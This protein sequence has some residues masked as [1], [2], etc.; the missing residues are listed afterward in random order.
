[1]AIGKKSLTRV[2]KYMT[3]QQKRILVYPAWKDNN[4]YKQLYKS[5]PNVEYTTYNGAFF[6]LL[7][8]FHIHKPDIIHLH[9]LTAYFAIDKSWSFKF[10]LRYFFSLADIVVLKATTN[11]KVV[12]TVH[13][14]YEHETKHEKME[15]LAKQLVALLSDKII[16]LGASAKALIEKTYKA[17]KKKIIV[18][19]HGH[20][21]DVFPKIALSKEECRKELDI[22]TDKTIFLFPGTAKE[23]KGIS[24][25]IDAFT[26]WANKKSVLIIAG[27]VSDEKIVMK[28]KKNKNILLHN[29]YIS[30][31]DLPKYFLAADWIIVPYK[32]IL[33]SA[34]ILT[35]MGLGCAVIAPAMGT[36]PDYLDEMGGVVYNAKEKDCVLLSLSKSLLLN[37][38]EMG[39]YNRNKAL[40]F[41]WESIANQ[42]KEIFNNL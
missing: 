7:K 18:S 3:N 20:F 2:V 38:S 34:T 11:V 5:I 42:T 15:V 1:M 37:H 41:N 29:L 27:K 26:K 33:T 19:S 14:L 12:W 13:N 22:P 6:T 28:A 10:L 35:A 24:I 30:D 36:I 8:N 25:L 23:Y 16:V 39:N 17:D 40:L 21:N 32:R 9:W 31:S 4:Y